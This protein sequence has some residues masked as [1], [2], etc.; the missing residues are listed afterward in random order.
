M[1]RRDC[2]KTE[3]IHVRLLSGMIKTISTQFFT[4]PDSVPWTLWLNV[5]A[6]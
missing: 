3:G 4:F 5:K 2:G 1:K 6:Q